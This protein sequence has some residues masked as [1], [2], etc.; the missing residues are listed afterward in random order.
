MEVGTEERAEQFHNLPNSN[1]AQ[2]VFLDEPK[3]HLQRK[4]ECSCQIVMKIA[5]DVL[6]R[7]KGEYKGSTLCPKRSLILLIPYN[8]MVGLFKPLEE[9]ESIDVNC[10]IYCFSKTRIIWKI[11]LVFVI[12][13]DKISHLSSERPQAITL[14]SSENPIGRNISGLNMPEFPIS[15]H[16][17]RPS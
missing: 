9:Y 6:T 12:C 2:R 5:C 1:K 4:N 8:I 10:D 14:T 13:Q 17:L 3:I 11:I 16:F 7:R 15:T